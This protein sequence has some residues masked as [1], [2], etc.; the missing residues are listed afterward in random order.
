MAHNLYQFESEVPAT[1]M[2]N[3]AS[4]ILYLCEYGWYEWI[5]YRNKKAQLLQDSEALGRYLGPAP[6]IGV[7]MCMQTY[8]E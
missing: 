8:I 3:G 1:W 4:D 5:Y 6:A 2:G 7:E